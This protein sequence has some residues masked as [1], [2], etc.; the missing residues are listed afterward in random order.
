[1]PGYEE[2][3]KMARPRSGHMHMDVRNRAKQ[4]APFDALRGFGESI[5]EKA[6]LYSDRPVLCEDRKEEVESALR[7]L[8]TGDRVTI[9]YFEECPHVKP[10]GRF[11][12]ISG[13]AEWVKG[14][15]AGGKLLLVEETEIPMGDIVDITNV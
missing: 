1:M 13:R 5:R 4:F 10:R 6:V 11:E 12:R 3:L 8:K 14:G 9:I 15:V 2:M 7:Q